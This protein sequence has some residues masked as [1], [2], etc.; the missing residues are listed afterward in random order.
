MRDD[1]KL[2]V[3]GGLNQEIRKPRSQQSLHPISS[4]LPMKR[5]SCSLI[6]SNATIAIANGAATVFSWNDEL[7]DTVGL[8]DPV[9]NNSRV[10]IPNTGRV[11]GLWLLHA[12]IRWLPGSGTYRRCEIWRNGGASLYGGRSQVLSSSTADVTQDA[13]LYFFDPNANDYFD[14]RL[15]HDSAGSINIAGIAES[16][17]EAIHL[18]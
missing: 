2:D 17:F 12:H 16:F 9:T 6:N 1:P 10:V 11:S 7:Y 15:S 8:H 5:A 14:V 4:T 3:F 18:W 13:W